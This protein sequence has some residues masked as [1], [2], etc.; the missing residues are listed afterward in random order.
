[1]PRRRSLLLAPLALL[2]A[3][4]SGDDTSQPP[5]LVVLVTVDQL[6]GDLI[7][8]YAPA[9]D[10]GFRR[11][12]DEG[13]LYTAASHNHSSTSTAI[14]HTTLGTGRY[15]VNHGIT[16]NS[17]TER[18]PDGSLR[19]VYAVE[20]LDSPILD[21]PSSEGRSPTNISVDGLGDWIVAADPEARVLSVSTKDRGAI[22]TAGQ[23]VDHH[24]YWWMPSDGRYVTSTYYETTYPDWVQR[25]NR[26]RIPELIADSI[27]EHTVPEEL[28]DLARRDDFAHEAD[29]VN[30]T[31]VHRRSDEVIT[32]ALAAELNWW[33]ATPKPDRATLEF[34]KTAIEALELGTRGHTDYLAISFSATDYVGHKYGPYSQ[35]QLA[36]LDALDGVLGELFDLLDARVGEDNW[37][38]ALSADHGVVTTPEYAAEIGEPGKRTT[39]EE[40]ELFDRTVEEAATA[41]FAAGM[42]TLEA[43]RAI[44]EAVEALPFVADVMVPE[45]ELLRG[46]PA[47]S[48]VA[49][50]QRS[51]TPGR[52]QGIVEW[53]LPVR[54]GE[55]VYTST[56]P[57]GTGHGSPYWYDRWVPVAFLGGDIRPGRSDEPVYTVDVAPTLAALAGAS[58]PAD[59][60][61]RALEVRGR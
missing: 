57:A 24:V 19:G 39:R 9:F 36:N 34:A 60:D 29:Q 7:D 11:L 30:T 6:R 44:A 54:Y 15:P 52:L 49:L 17:W 55:G 1:M 50:F 35:E 37:V 61:G 22:T 59:V 8:R 12:L 18:D 5:A 41:A 33:R 16:G 42:D 45:D 32:D 43:R 25:F 3:C 28:R 58:V 2:A 48:F 56:F 38:L 20:D 51:Y 40:M 46:E 10:G 26:E 53:D 14:G 21:Y 23:S 13:L 47:D 4:S 27:W 31:F